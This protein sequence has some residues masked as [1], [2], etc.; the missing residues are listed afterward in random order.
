MQ[1]KFLHRPEIFSFSAF[2]EL[3]CPRSLSLSSVLSLLTPTEFR[4]DVRCF[5]S[6]LRPPTSP[7]TTIT[8]TSTS[9][10]MNGPGN[11]CFVIH[12]SFVIRAS[13]VFFASHFPLLVSLTSPAR[14]HRPRPAPNASSALPFPPFRPQPLRFVR[15]R[16]ADIAREISPKTRPHLP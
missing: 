15:V 10:S 13:S 9:M 4:L 5:P 11:L 2:Q 3:F 7:S 1:I 8:S 6:D 12:S 16:E 14:M